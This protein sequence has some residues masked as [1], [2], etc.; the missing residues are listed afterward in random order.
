VVPATGYFGNGYE[1]TVTK[2]D[3]SKVEIRLDGSF[4]VMTGPGGAPS[5]PRFHA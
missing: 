4:D 1:A 2:S 5:P 3:G